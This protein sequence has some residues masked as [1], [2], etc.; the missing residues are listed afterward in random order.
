MN[1]IK[2]KSENKSEE[3]AKKAKKSDEKSDKSY[4]SDIQFQLKNFTEIKKYYDF[5]EQTI[6]SGM[7][8]HKMSEVLEFY[9]KIVQQ[10]LQPEEFHSLHE[11]TIFDDVEKSKLFELYGRII[12]AH[13]E[14]LRA[15]ILN[16]EKNS[17]STI[18]LVH[19]EI[20]G[21]KPM[22]LDIVKKM[23]HSWKIDNKNARRG[24][25]QYFG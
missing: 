23:Q 18:Q 4:K 12:I 1:T 10:I 15:I 9:L 24:P 8:L 5:T 16:D 11:C 25:T 21:V 6:T 20:L 3:K 22:M 17:L 7:I 14:V 2:S 19:S 13:R